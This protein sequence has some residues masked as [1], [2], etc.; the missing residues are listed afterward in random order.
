MFALLYYVWLDF[1]LLFVLSLLAWMLFG[2]NVIGWNVIDWNV[3][4]ANVQ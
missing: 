1:D 2:R 4:G 3:L